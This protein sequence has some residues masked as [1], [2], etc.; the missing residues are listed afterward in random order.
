[1]MR[2][3][4]ARVT[5]APSWVL[6]TAT[7]MTQGQSSTVRGILT[8]VHVPSTMYTRVLRQRVSWFRSTSS[9]GMSYS[10]GMSVYPMWRK[11]SPG[12]VSLPPSAI[13]TRRGFSGRVMMTSSTPRTASGWV[14][15]TGLVPERK[16]GLSMTSSPMRVASCGAERSTATRTFSR[17]L[18]PVPIPTVVV[19]AM[20]ISFL[21]ASRTAVQAR[22]GP[23]RGY[24]PVR[25][26]P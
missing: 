2:F 9:M 8:V 15:T 10:S 13:R 21:D 5:M 18:L 24:G 12:T 6:A 20:I 26:T 4:S 3:F 17:R 23:G 22:P 1:M 14:Q 7:E 11:H 16:F 19:D 25:K